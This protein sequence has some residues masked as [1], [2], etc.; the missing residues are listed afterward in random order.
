M[1]RSMGIRIAF[2]RSGGRNCPAGR[3]SCAEGDHFVVGVPVL[4]GW[5]FRGLALLGGGG[6]FAAT[7]LEGSAFGLVGFVGEDMNF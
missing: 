3:A 5:G 4:R 6:C 7:T 1:R 2:S